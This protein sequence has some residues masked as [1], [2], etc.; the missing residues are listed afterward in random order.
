MKQLEKNS[1]YDKY[2]TNEDGVVSDKEISRAEK[3]A[4]LENK[5]RK[6]DQLRHMAWV[7]MLSMVGFTIALFLPI[8]SVERLAALDNLLSMFYIAQAGVVATFFGSSA[9]MSRHA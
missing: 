1:A 5:D 3:L 6:E 2:D 9:Y 4:E 8:L 7:S